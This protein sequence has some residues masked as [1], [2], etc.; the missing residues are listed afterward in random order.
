MTDYEIVVVGAGIGGLTTAAL[1]AARG[2]NVCVLERQSAVGGCVSGV[3]KFGLTF[4]PSDGLHAGW[5]AVGIYERLF[6]ELRVEPPKIVPLDPTYS[7]RFSNQSEFTVGRDNRQRD[8]QLRQFFPECA[9][10]AIDFYEEIS[11]AGDELHEQIDSQPDVVWP[12]RTLP[13]LD[14]RIKN[15]PLAFRSFLDAQLQLLTQNTSDEISYDHAA[16]AL[17]TAHGKMFAVEGGAAS[18]ANKLAQSIKNSGGRIRLDA[19]VLRL[20]YDASGNAIGVDLLSGERVGASKAIVSNLTLWDTYGKLIG[21][22][23]TSVPIRTTLKTLT[24]WGA[25]LLFLSLDRDKFEAMPAER[26]LLLDQQNSEIDL[27][28]NMLFWNAGARP[29]AVSEGNRRA[30]TVHAFTEAEEWFSFHTDAEDL[31]QKDQATMERCWTLLHKAMPELG[32]SIE[33]IDTMTPRD[34]YE[35]TRRKFG[36]VGGRRS[37]FAGQGQPFLTSIPQLFI[38]SDTVTYGRLEGVT[39]LAWALAS[40]LS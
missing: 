32:D 39:R 26:L 21:L 15:F 8:E 33:I 29:V 12:L 40:Y 1:L 13:S 23:R 24:S 25:Y 19:P 28:T 2:M 3:E 30:V 31:E 37:H 7:I 11:R 36:M 5:G 9:I 35:Q 10:D 4:E 22:S 38:V 6:A 27:A 16:L 17:S 20:A 14:D 18:I 34:Y